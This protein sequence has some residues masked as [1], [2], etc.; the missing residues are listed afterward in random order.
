MPLRKTDMLKLKFPVLNKVEYIDLVKNRINVLTIEGKDVEGFTWRQLQLYCGEKLAGGVYGYSMKFAKDDTIY[1]GSIKVV[2]LTKQGFEMDEN[3]N[4]K[5]QL[6][7]LTKKLNSL[8]SDSPGM[9]L[10]ISLTKSGYETQISFLKDELARKEK[11][12]DKLEAEINKL[13]DQLDAAETIID[14]LK[15]KTGLSQYIQIAKEFLMMKSGAMKPI[16]N[17]KDSDTVDIPADVLQVLGV[18]DWSAVDEKLL[19][20]IIHYLKIF[21]QKLPLKGSTSHG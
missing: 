14:D 21:I 5:K 7:E 3:N 9:D 17:L 6:D 13:N 10:I 18:V 11:N 19:S 2:S 16:T 15:S 8:K 4:V 20:E 12:I 1:R